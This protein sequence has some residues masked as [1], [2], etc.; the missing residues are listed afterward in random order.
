M[1]VFSSILGG[2]EQLAFAAKKETAHR[3]TTKDGFVAETSKKSRNIY[4][5]V[6]PATRTRTPRTHARTHETADAT[7]TEVGAPGRS[8][9]P[10]AE[11]LSVSEALRNLA[12]AQSAAYAAQSAAHANVSAAYAALA[13]ALASDQNG[14]A[15]GDTRGSLLDGGRT[16]KPDGRKANHTGGKVHR[17]YYPASVKSAILDEVDAALQRTPTG[18]YAHKHIPR[19]HVHQCAHMHAH[20][21]AQVHRH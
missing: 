12:S 21:C 18:A 9:T 7:D 3:F 14:A 8:S 15:R 17:K 13:A 19:G 6:E 11:P 4:I 20:M 5:H 10:L 1:L 16:P 2:A